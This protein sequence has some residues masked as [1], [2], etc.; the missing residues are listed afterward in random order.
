ML[1]IVGESRMIQPG[2]LHRKRRSVMKLTT[3]E[4]IDRLTSPDSFRPLKA[5]HASGYLTGTAAVEGREV[6]ICASATDMKADADLTESVE[7]YIGAL[8]EARRR[9]K[10]FLLLMDTPALLQSGKGQYTVHPDLL[11]AGKHGMGAVYAL[12]GRMSGLVP[13]LCILFGGIGASLSF[14]VALCD[15]AILHRDSAMCLG[16][17][18]V[19]KAMIGEETTMEKLA[20]AAMHV[21]TS[22][23]GDMIADNDADALRLASRYLSFFPSSCGEL[24]PESKPEPPEHDSFSVPENTDVVFDMGTVISGL[25]DRGS[26]LELRGSNAREVMTGFARI[27]GSAV[28]IVASNSRQRGGILF[29]ESCRKMAR[30]I[31]LCD[32]FGIP[33][34]FLADV[35]GF[36]VG[37]ATESAGS[38]K[39]ASLLFST[40]SRLEVPHICIVVRKAY[41]AGLYAM[42]GSGFDPHHFIA[43]PHASI[44]I[45]GDKMLD[46]LIAHADMCDKERESF[47]E[48]RDEAHN[49]QLLKEKS[50]I[51]AVVAPEKL[52]SHIA[53]LQKD[54]PGRKSRKSPKPVLLV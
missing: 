48:L 11:L 15:A 43:L 19:V 5:G 24:P 6:V 45:F 22:A 47:R 36:M 32:A 1:F 52:R 29:P 31:S 17:P 34:V 53:S 51:D 41:T 16:T 33:L 35:P 21:T 8:G 10:P 12:H 26:F 28:G 40:I 50:L 44:S 3:E 4:R 18:E 13:Q 27:E 9:R 42:G 37:T 2:L 7:C 49:P 39:S 25:V 30:F 23:T 14:T 20:G 46:H 54:M 38:I